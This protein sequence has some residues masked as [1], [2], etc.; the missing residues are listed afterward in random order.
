MR[1][2]DQ[3]PNKQD[4]WTPG[5]PVSTISL[6]TTH[7]RLQPGEFV[8]L[9]SKQLISMDAIARLSEQFK[10]TD[11]EGRVLWLSGEE[12]QIWTIS[13]DTDPSEDS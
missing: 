1:T 11:L 12:W 13:A 7:I 6:N 9:H 2:H 5:G 3:E 4:A 10:G 8:V